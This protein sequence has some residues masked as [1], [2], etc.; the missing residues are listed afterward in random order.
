MQIRAKVLC[1]NSVRMPGVMA[2]HGWSVWVETPAG[3][4]LFDTGQ[5]L[6]LV[7]NATCFGIDLATTKAILISHHHYDHTGGLLAALNGI[8]AGAQRTEVPVHAHF[9]LFKESYVLRK[10]RKPR[11]VGIPFTRVALEGAGALFFLANGWRTVADGVY[12]TG[13][14]PRM[15]EFERGDSDLKHFDK[16]HELV[17]DPVRDDQSLV[18]ETRRGL[19]VVLGCSHAGIVNTLTYIQER[20]GRTDFHTVIGGTHLGAASEEQRVKTVEALGQFD[21]QHIG[22]SHCTGFGPAAE[23]ARSF[24]ERFFLCNVGTEVEI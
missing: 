5:G 4:F 16:D 24:G 22:V 15:T 7:S 10:A 6:T 13:E 17:F 12:L 3:D 21:I 11:Y 19:F 9:D 18:V 8:R 2:E 20:T 14:V 1:E 23:L